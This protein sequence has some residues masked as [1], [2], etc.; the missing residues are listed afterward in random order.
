MDSVPLV[1]KLYPAHRPRITRESGVAELRRYSQRGGTGD[2]DGAAVL[3]HHVLR[4]IH[5]LRCRWSVPVRSDQYAPFASYRAI[6]K[7]ELPSGNEGFSH[8]HD[9]VVRLDGDRERAVTQGEEVSGGLALG[10]ERRIDV[11]VGFVAHHGEVIVAADTGGT[12]D[13]DATVAKQ[14][15]AQGGVE[16]TGDVGGHEPVTAAE[17]SSRL[18]SVL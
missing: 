17:A 11:A 15:G 12:D 13:D 2:Q 4:D 14:R 9:A 18:P 8:D 10:A 1:F 3:D 7:S 5:A 6:A 16:T